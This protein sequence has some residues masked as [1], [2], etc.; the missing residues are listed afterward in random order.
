MVSKKHKSALSL[1]QI[2]DSI[3]NEDPEN[4]VS[5]EES[6]EWEFDYNDKGTEG[7]QS[8]QFS[9]INIATTFGS[10]VTSLP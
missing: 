9:E 2:L 10:D 4:D 7:G 1:E 3:F 6:S 5:E 8:L